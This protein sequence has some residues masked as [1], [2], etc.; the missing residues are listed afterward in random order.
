MDKKIRIA[1]KDLETYGYT[2]G[3]LR[4]GNLQKKKHRTSKHPNVECGTS[5]CLCYKENSHPKF[6]A[7]RHL[8]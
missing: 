6:Q 4:C 7:I 2:P 8:I 1:M 5:M 3:C